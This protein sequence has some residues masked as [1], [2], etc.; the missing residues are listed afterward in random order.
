MPN[1]EYVAGKPPLILNL[2][3]LAYPPTSKLEEMEAWPVKDN[4]LVVAL[5]EKIFDIEATVPDELAISKYASGV[6]SP[7]PSLPDEVEASLK[8]AVERELLA[9]MSLVNV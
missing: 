4:K 7:S 9:T 8:K 1:F 3:A 5:I 6:V 2:E